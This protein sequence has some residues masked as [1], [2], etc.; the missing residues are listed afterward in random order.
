MNAYN[1]QCTDNKT[2]YQSERESKFIFFCKTLPPKFPSF[3]R[4]NRKRNTSGE[5]VVLQ[6]GFRRHFPQWA[7][8]TLPSNLFHFSHS[9]STSISFCH[10]IA[11]TP[12]CHALVNYTHHRNLRT[13]GTNKKRTI[14]LVKQGKFKVGVAPAD[15]RVCLLLKNIFVGIMEGGSLAMSAGANPMIFR[16]I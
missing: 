6:I 9:F 7:T 10:G 13:G 4:S 8:R 12:Q 2:F 3:T 16:P 14:S 11:A 5:D 1:T 15:R